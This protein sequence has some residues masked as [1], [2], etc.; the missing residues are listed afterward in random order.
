MTIQNV[1]TKDIIMYVIL[2]LLLLYLVYSIYN[3]KSSFKELFFGY[4]Y[5]KITAVHYTDITGMI[6]LGVYYGV[7]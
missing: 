1:L 6:Y 2:I 3:K 4:Q 5:S 7:L